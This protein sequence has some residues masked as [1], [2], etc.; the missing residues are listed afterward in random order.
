[1]SNAA[2][3]NPRTDA[4]CALYRKCVQVCWNIEVGTAVSISFHL[5]AE[6]CQFDVAMPIL[7]NDFCY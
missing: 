5:R 2:A 1:M 4:F 7:D 6:E 3:W